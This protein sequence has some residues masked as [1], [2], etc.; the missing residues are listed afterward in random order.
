MYIYIH[1]NDSLSPGLSPES[2]IREFARLDARHH[3][4]IGKSSEFPSV[5]GI[6]V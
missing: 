1:I 2:T 6:L 5:S 4:L 3:A